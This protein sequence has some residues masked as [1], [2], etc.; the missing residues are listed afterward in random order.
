MFWFNLGCR[1]LQDSIAPVLTMKYPG[2]LKK[3][4]VTD[5]GNILYLDCVV[6]TQLPAFVKTHGSVHLKRVNFMV[7]K[8]YFHKAELSKERKKTMTC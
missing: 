7:F 4:S 2:I 5:D 3:Y 8:L 1:K 6:A